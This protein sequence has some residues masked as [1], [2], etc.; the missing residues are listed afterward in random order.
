MVLSA[1]RSCSA[2]SRNRD[3]AVQAID[4][5]SDLGVFLQ[6]RRR[7][8]N[9][10]FLKFFHVPS[11]RWKP[12][13]HHSRYVNRFQV[14]IRIVVVLQLARVDPLGLAKRECPQFC[15]CR[16][17]LLDRRFSGFGL[18]RIEPHTN[19][20]ENCPGVGLT[21]IGVVGQI[22]ED[23]HGVRMAAQDPMSEQHLSRLTR[24]DATNQGHLRAAVQLGRTRERQVDRRLSRIAWIAIPWDY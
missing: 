9:Q 10:K 5:K 13:P 7:N 6:Q 19:C 17:Q 2:N 22:H 3:Q 24:A 18:E 16:S 21:K 4:K 12:E 15:M 20:G 11:K 1:C 8:R 23:V 14:L